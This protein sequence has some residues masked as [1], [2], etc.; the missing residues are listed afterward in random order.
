MTICQW[1]QLICF[2][3]S[4]LIYYYSFRQDC[5]IVSDLKLVIM[6]NQNDQSWQQL[7][8]VCRCV[9]E[10]WLCAF[11]NWSRKSAPSLFLIQYDLSLLSKSQLPLPFSPYLLSFLFYGTFCLSFSIC[12]SLPQ[13]QSADSLSTCLFLFL[14]LTFTYLPFLFFYRSLTQLLPP[15]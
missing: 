9:S 5:N 11:L 4:L 1:S 2:C 7:N 15:L 10:L 12:K 14:T 8:T 3:L 6:I 13:P